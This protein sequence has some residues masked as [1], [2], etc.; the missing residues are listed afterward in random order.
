MRCEGYTNSVWARE[1]YRSPGT[2][3]PALQ[4]GQWHGWVP[5]SAWVIKACNNVPLVVDEAQIHKRSILKER[6]SVF[7]DLV[8][9]IP[10]LLCALLCWWMCVCVCVCSWGRE[11]NGKGE[12]KK[13]RKKGRERLWEHCFSYLPPHSTHLV[14]P[15]WY[16]H[17]SGRLLPASRKCSWRRLT[18]V[19]E[20]LSQGREAARCVTGRTSAKF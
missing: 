20:I 7:S 18:V 9:F 13:K 15:L 6:Y 14:F 17:F 1:I 11:R 4:T 2:N 10:L 16:P 19:D 3:T 8:H 12:R 5:V